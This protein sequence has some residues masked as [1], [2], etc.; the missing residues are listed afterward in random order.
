MIELISGVSPFGTIQT[1]NT[2]HGGTEAVGVDF[3]SNTVLLTCGGQTNKVKL[4]DISVN[5]ANNLM[6]SSVAQM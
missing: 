6:T 3:T 2:G 4:W 1:F 5:P